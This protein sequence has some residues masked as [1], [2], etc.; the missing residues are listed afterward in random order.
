MLDTEPL[1]NLIKP[2]MDKIALLDKQARQL[3]RDAAPFFNQAKEKEIA[4]NKKIFKKKQDSEEVC[5]LYQKSNDLQEAAFELDRERYALEEKYYPTQNLINKV[6]WYNLFGER[7]PYYQTEEEYIK[8]MG[9]QREY[10][11]SP[12]NPAIEPIYR[13]AYDAYKKLPCPEVKKILNELEDIF[14]SKYPLKW[15]KVYSELFE[16]RIKNMPKPQTDDYNLNPNLFIE[17]SPVN[18]YMTDIRTG[19]WV[20]YK[21]GNYVDESGNQVPITYID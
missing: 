20:Y 18:T 4:L 3:Q 16:A 14:S 8:R 13:I 19:G 11:S 12:T 5:A 15:E 2:Y 9:S 7:F 17:T 21:D 1:K 10:L 6:D